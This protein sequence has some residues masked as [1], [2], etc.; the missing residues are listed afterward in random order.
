M[1]SENGRH[2]HSTLLTGLLEY[3]VISVMQT[4]ICVKAK[5]RGLFLY[6]MKDYGPQFI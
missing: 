4:R 6:V 1:L 5:T 2:T 3:A